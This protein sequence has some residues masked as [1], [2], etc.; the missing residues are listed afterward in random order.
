MIKL[1]VGHL[2][3]Q[4][5]TMT[6]CAI[7]GCDYRSDDGSG[8]SFFGI[9]KITD[10]YGQADLELRKKRRDGILA[11][12][13][14]QDLDLKALHKYKVCARH[15]RSGRSANLYETTDP[16]WLPTLHLGHKKHGSIVTVNPVSSDA[17]VDRWRRAHERE[18]WKKIEELLPGVVTEEVRMGSCCRRD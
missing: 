15:Y 14:R 1:R 3:A 9:P 2:V 5:A 13:N 4:V 8:I 6:R 18:K 12:I 10:Q 16:D 11:A 17:S 7:V